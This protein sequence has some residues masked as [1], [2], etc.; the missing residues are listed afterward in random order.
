[1]FRGCGSFI[2]IRPLVIKI[3]APLKLVFVFPVSVA[4]LVHAIITIIHKRAPRT[5]NSAV[6]LCAAHE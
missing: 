5:F 3:I 6:R 4:I 1:M 2:L